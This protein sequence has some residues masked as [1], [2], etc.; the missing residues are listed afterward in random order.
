MSKYTNVVRLRLKPG[1]QEVFE[2]I[3]KA[4]DK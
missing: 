3:F 4:T 1:Q 2:R